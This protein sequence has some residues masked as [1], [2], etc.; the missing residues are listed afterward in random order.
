MAGVKIRLIVR[1]TCSLVAGV[2][3]ISENIEA[4]SILDK[5]LEH[6]R[7]FIFENNGNEEIF[8]G[9]ADMMERNLD[10]RIEALLK[11]QDMKIKNQLRKIFEIQW[12]DSVKA[13][14]LMQ[15]HLNEYM[16]PD[17]DHELLRSQPALYEYFKSLTDIKH[18]LENAAS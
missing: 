6:T 12:S 2:K 8:V 1:S 7:I 11:V 13:R 5:F 16:Q 9:S 18:H 17:E 3:G 15:G 10:A 14:S 4:I